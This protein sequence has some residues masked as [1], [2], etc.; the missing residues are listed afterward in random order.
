MSS[1]WKYPSSHYINGKTRSTPAYS[2]WSAMIQRVG[3]QKFYEHVTISENFKSFDY[4]YEWG[5]EQKGFLVTDSRGYTWSLDKDIVGDGTIY[6]EDVCVFVPAE[7]NNLVKSSGVSGLPNGV[8][9]AD[10]LGKSFRATGNYL[11]NSFSLGI[12]DNVKHAHSMYLTFRKMM[13]EDIMNRYGD[14][15]DERVYDSLL[16]TCNQDNYTYGDILDSS[17]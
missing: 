14:T 15:V 3:K 17:N 9:Y 1:K 2:K 13:I 6:S 8:T 12:S 10:K 7:I 16:E 11:G 5:L 4:W